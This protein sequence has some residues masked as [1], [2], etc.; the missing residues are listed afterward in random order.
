MVIFNLIL[1]KYSLFNVSLETL[2]LYS[3]LNF[4]SKGAK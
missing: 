4:L 3:R 2:Y 1:I